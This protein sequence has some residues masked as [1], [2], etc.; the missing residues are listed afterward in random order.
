VR[1]EIPCGDYLG[2]WQIG[3]QHT[4]GSL[5]ATGNVQAFVQEAYT[6]YDAALGVSKGAWNAQL[7]GQNLTSVNASAYTNATLFVQTQ[8]VIRPRVVGVKFGYK[9]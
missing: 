3:A 5:S 6:T 1:D 9:F 7:F 2:F 4:G 8:T